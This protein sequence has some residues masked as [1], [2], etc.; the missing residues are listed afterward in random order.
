MLGQSGNDTLDGGAGNDTIISS[1]THSHWEAIRA[2]DGDDLIQ[3][4]GTR[5]VIRTGTGADAAF[6]YRLS[7]FSRRQRPQK[8]IFA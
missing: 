3:T 8:M 7:S 1:G 4:S 5:A 2:G 6:G